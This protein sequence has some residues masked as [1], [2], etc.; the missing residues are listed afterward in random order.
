MVV[1]LYRKWHSDEAKKE[2][3]DGQ[4]ND[5]NITS[6]PHC[7]LPSNDVDDQRI[8]Y[9]P[10]DYQDAVGCDEADESRLVHPPIGSEALEEGKI[11]LPGSLP[12][13]LLV[14]DPYC[15]SEDGWRCYCG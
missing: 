7:R 1:G 5:E 2:I 11:Q 13:W 3:R 4:I 14:T 6:S 15:V 9:R 12:I 10:D 8:A